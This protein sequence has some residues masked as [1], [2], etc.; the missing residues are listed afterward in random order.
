MGEVY[1][2]GSVM[3]GSAPTDGFEGG[4]VVR[5]LPR[6]T[7]ALVAPLHLAYDTGVCDDGGVEANGFLGIGVAPEGG[8]ANLR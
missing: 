3:E 5:V 8:D 4:E 6:H 7:R 2:G 1:R